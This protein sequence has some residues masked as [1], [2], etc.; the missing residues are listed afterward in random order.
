MDDLIHGREVCAVLS[1][2]SGLPVV[3]SS[4]EEAVIAEYV[5]VFPEDKTFC[6]GIY[7]RPYWLDI[8]AE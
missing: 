6:I 3:F 4:G 5:K 1:E 7:T 8:T 2:K